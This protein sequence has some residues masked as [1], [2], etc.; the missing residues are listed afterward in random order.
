MNKEIRCAI[1]I[2]NFPSLACCVLLLAQQLDVTQPGSHIHEGKSSMTDVSFPILSS[3]TV[4]LMVDI[5]TLGPWDKS[6]FQVDHYLVRSPSRGGGGSIP[7][8]I[9]WFQSEL[10]P[11]PNSCCALAPPID[12]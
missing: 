2:D 10:A 6:I 8:G 12:P 5:F 3:P 7:I 1:A 9:G 11:V 4:E